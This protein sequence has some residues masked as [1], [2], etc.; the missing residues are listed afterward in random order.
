[1][2]NLRFSLLIVVAA[3][4]TNNVFSC[5]PAIAKPKILDDSYYHAYPGDWGFVVKNNRYYWP[6]MGDTPDSP[7]KPTAELKQLKS[8]AISIGSNYFCS[9]KSLNKQLKKNPKAVTANCTRD[10]WVNFR[11]RF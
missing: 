1:M 11:Q 9:I 8:G 5:N 6:G 3:C 7:L 10:G 2:N 4:L